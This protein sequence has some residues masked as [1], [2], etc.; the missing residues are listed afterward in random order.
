MPRSCHF[1]LTTFQL[2]KLI[3]KTRLS[4]TTINNFFFGCVLDV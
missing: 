4:N 2:Y 3:L 1:T